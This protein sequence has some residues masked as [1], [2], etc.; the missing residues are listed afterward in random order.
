MEL[1]NLV[2]ILM[3][4]QDRQRNPWMM[5]MRPRPVFPCPYQLGGFSLGNEHERLRVRS[6]VVHRQAW[7]MRMFNI[8][9]K[10][11]LMVQY[12][13]SLSMDLAIYKKYARTVILAWMPPHRGITL[14]SLDMIF[15]V[16]QKESKYCKTGFGSQLKKGERHGWQYLRLRDV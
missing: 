10:E 14:L 15:R 9:G 4:S 13:C 6:T 8:N 11:V 2:K 3:T 7:F 16:W 1:P 5:W 12:L